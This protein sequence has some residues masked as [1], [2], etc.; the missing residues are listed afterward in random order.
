MNDLFIAQLIDLPNTYIGE[1]PPGEDTCQWISLS[2]GTSET[3]FGL[4][5]I[6]KPEYAIYVRDPSN[7]VA[8]ERAQACFNKLQNWN[9]AHRALIVSRL[10]AFVGK[11]EKLRSVY[12]FRIQLITGG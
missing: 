1:A 7:K 10:P 3:F 11:D 6:D 8:I 12:S 9:D 2:A 5:T 4:Q